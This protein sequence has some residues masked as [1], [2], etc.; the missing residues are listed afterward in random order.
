MGVF[1]DMFR[2]K[3]RSILTITGIAV[4]VFALV[5]L[6]AASENNN[7]Y[8]VKL[9]KY[10]E[11]TIS[12][13]E[14]KDSNFF[15]LATG[16][17][18]LSMKK[19]AEIAAYP[20]VAAAFP[21]VNILMDED[22]FS[23]IPPMIM[24][25]APGMIE[26]Q[27]LPLTSGRGMRDGERGVTILGSDIARRLKAK[28]G[29]T[30]D[31]RGKPFEVVGIVERTFINLSDASAYVGLEDARQLY[32][33]SLPK[34]FQAKVKPD[35]LAVGVMVYARDGV[36]PNEL[37]RSLER[38]VAGIV[39]TGPSDMMRNVN[40]MISLLN[41]VV[42]SVAAIALL[43]GAFSIVNTMMMAV[44]ER[45]REI[46]VKRA[47]G[48][49]RGRVARDVLAESAVMGGMGGALGLAFGAVVAYGLNSALVAATGTSMFLVTGRLAVGAIVFS[50][51][52]GAIG[53]LYPATRASRLDPALALAQR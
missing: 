53:G 25:V 38:D 20:G 45:T 52:L 29:D 36:D 12:V 37:A 4:G 33:E 3:G 16:A 30:I 6:G 51:A 44:T 26:Y 19:A 24:S 13:T 46:G 14:T 49:T 40:S 50:M 32:V 15:G 35:D 17:R 7:V 9:T 34:A 10:F 8:S 39:T 11:N 2:R 42:G 43:V 31:L 48:A 1:R 47:L 23:V 22:F 5:V 18:P 41:A 27:G 21:Q 28:V